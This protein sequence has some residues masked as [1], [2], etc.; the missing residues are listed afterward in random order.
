MADNLDT[1]WKLFYGDGL[2]LGEIA[3]KLG[4]GIYDL[5]PWLTAPANRLAMDGA[6]EW[7][8][9]HEAATQEIERLRSLLRR[10]DDV[11]TWE[12]TPLGRDFQEEIEAA[13]GIAE[14][15]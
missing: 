13:I 1:A 4:C 11:I 2:T 8:A 10:I 7:M 3:E 5:S 14:K 9:R 6:M 12:T 15:P